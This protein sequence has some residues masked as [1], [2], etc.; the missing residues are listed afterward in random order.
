MRNLGLSYVKL[1]K[2]YTKEVA[3]ATLRSAK[4]EDAHCANDERTL[5][6]RYELMQTLLPHIMEIQLLTGL[7]V[8][9]KCQSFVKGDFS[10]RLY[11]VFGQ[12]R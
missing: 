3:K 7:P 12:L 9:Q 2:P 5:K 6:L 1:R 10:K 4:M 8:P 11:L